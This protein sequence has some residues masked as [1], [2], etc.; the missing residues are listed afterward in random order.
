LKAL[1]L[2]DAAPSK[3]EPRR[4]KEDELLLLLCRQ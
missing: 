4:C 3:P 2:C 1:G